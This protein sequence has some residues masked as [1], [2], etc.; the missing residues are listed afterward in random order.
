MVKE[1]MTTADRT[2]TGK[3][4]RAQGD[5]VKLNRGRRDTWNATP[6]SQERLQ[7]LALRAR[8]LSDAILA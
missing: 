8:P 5:G 2:A 7:E 1:E 3:E 4:T 6:G